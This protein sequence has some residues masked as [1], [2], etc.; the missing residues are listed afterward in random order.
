M[1]EGDDNFAPG[2]VKFTMFAAPTKTLAPED[3]SFGCKRLKEA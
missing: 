3:I 2:I 1:G